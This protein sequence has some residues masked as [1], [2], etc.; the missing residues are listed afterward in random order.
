[1][2]SSSA[3]VPLLKALFGEAVGMNRYKWNR[4]SDSGKFDGRTAY[5]VS[6]LQLVM[7]P[8]SVG[9]AAVARSATAVHANHLC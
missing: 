4:L 5:V 3:K 8:M 7:S 9:S 1:M 2:T 6:L